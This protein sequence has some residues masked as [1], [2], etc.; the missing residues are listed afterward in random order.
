MRFLFTPGFG[1]LPEIENILVE[2]NVQTE[3]DEETCQYIADYTVDGVGYSVWVEDKDSITVKLN[4][5]AGYQLAGVACWRLG[6]EKADVWEPI[7]LYLQQ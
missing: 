7:A 3:W 2:N 6:Q 5:M 4:V 1:L